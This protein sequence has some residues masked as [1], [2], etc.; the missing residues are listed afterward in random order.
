MTDPSRGAELQAQFEQIRAEAGVHRIVH[1]TN[2]RSLLGTSRDLKAARNKFEFA[3]GMDTPAVL[4]A[5]LRDDVVASGVGALAF[6]VLDVLDTTAEM[7]ADEI[8][9]D[10]AALAAAWRERFDPDELY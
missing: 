3:V 1:A 8:D 6:E 2:G 9:A 10:L 7:T 5:R 4:D